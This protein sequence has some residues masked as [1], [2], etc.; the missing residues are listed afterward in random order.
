M[1][2]DMV[3]YVLSGLVNDVLGCMCNITFSALVD[4]T[5]LDGEGVSLRAFNAILQ[6]LGRRRPLT[7]AWGLDT[8]GV[9][10]CGWMVDRRGGFLAHLSL[11]TRYSASSREWKHGRSVCN[12]VT[13]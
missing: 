11:G 12:I 9:A 8:A 10:R 6:E 1:R 4:T 13:C 5:H 3:S 2:F 7:T